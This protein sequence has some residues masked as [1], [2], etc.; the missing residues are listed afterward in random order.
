MVA[1]SHTTRR[2]RLQTRCADSSVY[3]PPVSPPTLSL[4]T[5]A[6]RTLV[7]HS[8]PPC[9]PHAFSQHASFPPLL[10]RVPVPR[11]RESFCGLGR[12]FGRGGNKKQS[13]QRG[14]DRRWHHRRRRHPA[15]I[16]FSSRAI[17]LTPAKGGEGEK[18]N[19]E[20]CCVSSSRNPR[21]GR[22]CIRVIQ[23]ELE[24]NLD[25]REIL[26][27]SIIRLSYEK[28]ENSMWECIYCI[29]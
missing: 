17:S 3:S 21:K 25:I 11:R 2:I 12:S 22:I 6:D 14:V 10:P 15:Q 20:R 16:S 24:K 5:A 18:C 13:S 8:E 4:L 26:K 28:F 23:W 9:C 29:F 7:F 19:P 1:R 27:E